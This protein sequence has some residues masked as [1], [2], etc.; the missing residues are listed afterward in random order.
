MGVSYSYA[1]EV[2]E[3]LRGKIAVT[4]AL[5]LLSWL[6]VTAV[7]IPLGIA[8]AR[9]K[10]RRLER[11]S[12]SLNQLLMSVPSFF[13]GILLTWLFGLVLHL[14]TPG[15]FVP[16]S[17]SFWGCLGYL[18]FPALAISV[19]KTAKTAK[20][21]RSAILGEMKRD[22]VLTAYSHGNSRWMVISRHVLRNAMLPVVTYLA[23]S[24]AD[25]VA[26]SII[27][28]QVFVVPGLGRL[29]IA[30]ISNRDFPV[31]LCIVVMIAFVVVVM[32]YLADLLTQAIDPR[33]RLS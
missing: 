13:L 10:G 1:V 8:L 24:L 2:R 16:F 29:L 22:Y 32:N 26:S 27:V 11:I 14:F 25:I 4:A 7:S 6:L 19:P 33:V 21:L 12:V 17:E 20:L 23:M 15:R 3:V 30:S 18:F 28:E 9:Y 31:A 5:S